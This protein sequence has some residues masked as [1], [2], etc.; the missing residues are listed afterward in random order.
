MIT[1][2]LCDS[3][4]F[5]N[6]SN[7]LH[8]DI[9][10]NNGVSLLNEIPGV[11]HT[12]AFPAYPVEMMECIDFIEAQ[13]EVN[14]TADPYLSQQ[15]KLY[16]NPAQNSIQLNYPEEWLVQQVEILNVSGQTFTPRLVNLKTI[17][18][19]QLANGVYFLRIITD[20]GIAVQQIAIQH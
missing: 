16:P 11:G 13:Y 15:L 7:N 18:S 14:S 3:N 4:N 5:I 20:E 10:Q 1:F 2:N 6:V 12:V 17:D 19:S 9:Q 8:D